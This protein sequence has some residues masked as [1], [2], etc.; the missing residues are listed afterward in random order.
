MQSIFQFLC[1][2]DGVSSIEYAL[3]ALFIAVVIFTAVT[4]I[5]MTL[6]GIFQSVTVA[7]S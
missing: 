2:D 3:L 5:G 6:S 7:F 4:S 1:K